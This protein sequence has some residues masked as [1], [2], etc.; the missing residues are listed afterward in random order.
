MKNSQFE[1]IRNQKFIALVQKLPTHI[2][3][4]AAKQFQLLQENPLYPPLHFKKV[5]GLWSLRITD[6]Y[7][8]LGYEENGTIIWF[9]I[10]KH[11]EYER[12]I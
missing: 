4:R 5:S 12:R 6:D 8:A 10:G 7:R 11:D 3:K 2:Q 9:W 1:H